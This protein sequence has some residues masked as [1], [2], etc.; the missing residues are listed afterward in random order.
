MV[1]SFS[2]QLSIKKTVTG[3]ASMAGPTFYISHNSIS[4]MLQKSILCLLSVL[5]STHLLLAQ[6]AM[7]AVKYLTA[8]QVID[9]AQT[10]DKPY[11]WVAV[12]IPKCAQAHRIFSDRVLFYNKHKDKLNI[13]M[14]S[15]LN[16]TDNQ[17]IFKNY[18]ETFQYTSPFYAIDSS[19]QQQG[20]MQTHIQFIKDLR[21]KLDSGEGFVENIIIDNKGKIVYA[22]E[23]NLN[24]KVADRVLK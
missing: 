9:M 12:Y 23:G 1:L 16:S 21:Q 2:L 10:Q 8:Q 19:Y 20:I 7:P 15:V 11:L 18:S 3:L 22:E 6:S 24:P 14:V 4:N 17:N 13:V 5:L